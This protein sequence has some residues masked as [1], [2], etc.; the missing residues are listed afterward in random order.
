M[1]KSDKIINNKLLNKDE[2]KSLKIRF[3]RK[4]DILFFSALCQDSIFSKDEIYF[5]KSNKTLITTF[6]RFCWE[7]QS[8]ELNN[9]TFYRVV[10][11]FRICNVNEVIYENFEKLKSL[12]FFSLLSV[13]YKKNIITLHFSCNVDIKIFITKIDIFLDDL[14][15]PWPTIRKPQHK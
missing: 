15:I 10:S 1:K 7:Y 6:S 8:S 9:S 5:D 3:L 13:S 4:K 12:E 11:G 14:D 2:F